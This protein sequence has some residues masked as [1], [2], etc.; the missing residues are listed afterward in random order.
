MVNTIFITG[1]ADSGKSRWAV[2]RLA[3]YNNVLF[4][5]THTK[6]SHQTL[7]RIKYST[8]LYGVNWDIQTGVV[9]APQNYLGRHSYV[10]FDSLDDYAYHTLLRECP[11]IEKINDEIRNNVQRKLI[12]DMEALH[13]HARDTGGCVIITTLEVGFS[14]M[15]Q[16]LFRKELRGIVGTVNQRIANISDEVYFSA[17][18][19]QVLMKSRET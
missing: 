6:V 15:P 19:V 17:S 18:G 5:D 11:N 13:N 4:L 8:D 10:I 1:G 9:D 16:D 12:S 14:L 7:N 3:P 2:T